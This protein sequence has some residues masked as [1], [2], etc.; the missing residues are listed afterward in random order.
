MQSVP[1]TGTSRGPGRALAHGFSARGQFG[2][3][4]PGD[5]FQKP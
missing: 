4:G 1:V 3:A 5:F 2:G